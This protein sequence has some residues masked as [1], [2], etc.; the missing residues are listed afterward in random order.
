[1]TENGRSSYAI[2]DYTA[3]KIYRPQFNHG[4]IYSR[5][6]VSIKQDKKGT[7]NAG[8]NTLYA[9]FGELASCRF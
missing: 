9:Q 7:I 2:P 5:Q 3:R 8:C 1:M 4:Q 6:S